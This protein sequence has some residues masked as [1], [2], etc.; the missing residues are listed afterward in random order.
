MKVL[1]IVFIFFIVCSL[2][3]INNHNL[4][5][6]EKQDFNEFSRVGFSWADKFYFNMQAITS[7]VIKLNWFPE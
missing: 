2:I 5:I 6:F 3:I 4:K 7:N 1:I